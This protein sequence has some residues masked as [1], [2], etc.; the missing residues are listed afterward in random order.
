MSTKEQEILD[1]VQLLIMQATEHIIQASCLLTER[2]P[3][4]SIERLSRVQGVLD[5][6]KYAIFHMKWPEIEG[7]D[8]ERKNED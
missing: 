6:A 8:K 7:E 5:S 4:L 2:K 3:A 1:K